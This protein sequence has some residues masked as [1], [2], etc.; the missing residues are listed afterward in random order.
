LV[1]PS[2]S[3][4][5]ALGNSFWDST[6]RPGHLHT[7]GDALRI[8]PALPGVAPPTDRPSDSNWIHEIKHDGYRMMARRDPVGIR[9]ITRNGHDWTERYPLVVE[10]MNH[11]KVRSCLIDG[12]VVCCDEK[13]VAAFQL[14]RHRRNE[15]QAFLYAF[16]LLELNGADLRREPIEVRKATLASILRK[17]RDGV[18]LNEHLEHPEGDVVFRHACKGR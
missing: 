15:A 10:A 5:S 13:G 2:Y 16:D 12:E 14:R 9:L 11:L 4:N 8:H 7:L 1:T 18:R 6:L 3:S 17:S